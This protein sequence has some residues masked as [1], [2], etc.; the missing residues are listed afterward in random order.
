MTEFWPVSYIWSD[1]MMTVG[2]ALEK[3]R[4]FGLVEGLK[5]DFKAFKVEGTV[6]SKG[7]LKSLMFP[8]YGLEIAIQ[9]KSTDTL[10]LTLVDEDGQ[11]PTCDIITP[12][13]KKV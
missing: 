7:L 2:G 5:V 9:W 8:I 4:I 13:A 10:Q 1:A 3:I 6:W 11:L 12:C